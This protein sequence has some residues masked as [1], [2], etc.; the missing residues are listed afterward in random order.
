MGL[1]LIRSGEDGGAQRPEASP[2]QTRSSSC[3]LR[4]ATGGIR[5]NDKCGRARRA[6][7]RIS[8]IDA[9]DALCHGGPSPFR[10]T[11]NRPD[12][13]EPRMI[14]RAKDQYTYMTRPRDELRQALGIT[15][16]VA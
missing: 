10:V 11:P 12:R 3:F 5:S 15:R 14:K 13:D 4:Y 16:L 7:D 1:G 6:P 9:F 2:P 8:F